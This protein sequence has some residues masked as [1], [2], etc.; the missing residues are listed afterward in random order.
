M[1][2]V[3]VAVVR[4][5]CATPSLSST[6]IHSHSP[7]FSFIYFFFFCLLFCKLSANFIP[8]V[9]KICLVYYTILSIVLVFTKRFTSYTSAF[10][11]MYLLLLCKMPYYLL[12]R[13]MRIIL[14]SY[15]FG[16]APNIACVDTYI[17]LTLFSRHSKL[18]IELNV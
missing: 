8:I 2:G 17:I 6:Y 15:H 14:I 11:I 16:N 3:V 10:L 13:Y 4:I 5:S 18:S 12:H 9:W 7:S 1:C